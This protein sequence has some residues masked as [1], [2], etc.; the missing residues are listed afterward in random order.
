MLGHLF[1]KVNVYGRN[2][3]IRPENNP[4]SPVVTNS[5]GGDSGISLILS[6]YFDKKQVY[7]TKSRVYHIS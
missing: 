2:K 4:Q 5:V 3:A 6:S 1:C 7:K